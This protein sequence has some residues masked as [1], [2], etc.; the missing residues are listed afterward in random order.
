MRALFILLVLALTSCRSVQSVVTE[1][2]T[3]TDSTATATA[4]TAEVTSVKSDFEKTDTS[5]ET[6]TITVIEPIDS[7]V[8]IR[9]VDSNGGEVLHYNSKITE[10]KKK[11][12]KDIK[13]NASIDW[14]LFKFNT[15]ANEARTAHTAENF[16]KKVKKEVTL[17]SYWWVALIALIIYIAWRLRKFIPIVGAF[18]R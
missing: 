18:I 3:T 14:E 1:E 7:S 12:H 2:K 6:V 11:V 15:M 13:E 17:L 4:T 16:N 9:I 10:T 5:E 8:P